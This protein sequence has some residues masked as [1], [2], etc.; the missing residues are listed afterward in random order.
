VLVGGVFAMVRYLGAKEHALT[1]INYFMVASILGSL[2]FVNHWRMP[3]GR[4]WIWVVAIGI[5]GLIGQVF[6]TKAFQLAD[7][8]TIAPFKYMEL[9]YAL[10]LGLIFLDEEHNNLAIFGML[11]IVLGMVLNVY[12]KKRNSS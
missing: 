5:V 3:I 10:G 8:N 6:M 1:I 11:L 7:T 2:F 9:I 12:F 4:E